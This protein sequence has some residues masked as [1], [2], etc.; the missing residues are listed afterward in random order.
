GRHRRP[1]DGHLDGALTRGGV[2][3]RLE[4]GRV[5]VHHRGRGRRGGVRD[6]RRRLHL[7]RRGGR[8]HALGIGRDGGRGGHRRRRWRGRRRG[9]GGLVHLAEAEDTM[10]G[11]VGDVDGVVLLDV[12]HH[13]GDGLLALA[14]I[15]EARPQ[16]ADPVG[17]FHGEGDAGNVFGLAR[18]EH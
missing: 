7:W 10:A 17:G 4:G 16:R 14:D 3:V 11:D 2:Q 5:V 8:W 15:R 6:R 1:R 12:T 18:N 13:V 9:D